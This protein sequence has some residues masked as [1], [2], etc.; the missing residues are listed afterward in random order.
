MLKKD[1]E[2]EAALSACKA[3]SNQLMAEMMS[4]I[5]ADAE[6]CSKLESENQQLQDEREKVAELQKQLH[7]LQDGFER[8]TVSTDKQMDD[9]KQ[10]YQQLRSS[11]EHAGQVFR[12][13]GEQACIMLDN[14]DGIDDIGS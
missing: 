8:R 11:H 6:H 1:E 12:S 3:K 14:L 10:A 13:F 4:K 5:Q 9:I 7:N 2:K